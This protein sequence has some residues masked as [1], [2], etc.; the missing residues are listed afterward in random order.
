MM[1]HGSIKSDRTKEKPLAA[2][3]FGIPELSDVILVIE[4]QEFHVHKMVYPFFL[5]LY[6]F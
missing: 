4:E 2:I 5:H 6:S 1:V 3:Q